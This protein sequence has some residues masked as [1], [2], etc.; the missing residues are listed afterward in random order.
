MGLFK[1]VKILTQFFY[2]RNFYFNQNLW[3]S[4]NGKKLKLFGNLLISSYKDITAPILQNVK[5]LSFQLVSDNDHDSEGKSCV[6]YLSFGTELHQFNTSIIEISEIL[7]GHENIFFINVSND[8]K[9]C[10]ES[11]NCYNI[12]F[13]SIDSTTFSINDE[14]HHFANSIFLKVEYFKQ[15]P[16]IQT[17]YWNLFAKSILPIFPNQTIEQRN[18]YDLNYLS[19]TSISLVFDLI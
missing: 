11:N 18:F 13:E 7:Q 10:F 9:Y 16:A 15:S 14:S 19:S 2:H 8:T 17:V 6:C 3:M 12:T 4:E 1:T 5:Y